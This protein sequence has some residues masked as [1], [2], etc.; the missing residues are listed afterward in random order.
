VEDSNQD[1]ASTPPLDPSQRI[2]IPIE[3]RNVVGDWVF[4][5]HDKDQYVRDQHTG[6]IRRKHPKVNGKL[7]KRARQRGGP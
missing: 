3:K 1:S 4:Q 5:T 6:V 2:W 7:A